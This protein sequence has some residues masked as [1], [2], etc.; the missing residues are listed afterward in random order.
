VGNTWNRDQLLDTGRTITSFGQDSAGEVYVV[1]QS[2]SVLSWLRSRTNS[3]EG[4]GVL[5]GHGQKHPT[6]LLL[7][8][9]NRV[10]YCGSLL[11]IGT[12]HLDGGAYGTERSD[13]FL[14]RRDGNGANP[15]WMDHLSLDLHPS[16]GFFDLLS[17]SSR[18]AGSGGCLL[19]VHGYVHGTLRGVVVRMAPLLFSMT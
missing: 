13:Q 15:L 11:R 9:H 5:C 3:C 2:G 17:T 8:R 18:F 4:E 10:G 19:L 7:D 14:Y 16:S 6:D 12:W 1:D